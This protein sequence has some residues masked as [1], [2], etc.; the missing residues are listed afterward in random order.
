M[1]A[2]AASAEMP[3]WVY[4][5]SSLGFSVGTRLTPTRK[6]PALIYLWIVSIV[7]VLS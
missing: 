1:T 6:S 3:I 2:Y 5:S 4:G 7:R